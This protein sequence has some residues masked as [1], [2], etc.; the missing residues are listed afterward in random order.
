MAVALPPDAACAE[1][2]MIGLG[3]SDLFPLPN[4]ERD[5]VRGF[6]LIDRLEP[7]TPTLSPAERGSGMSKPRDLA[8]IRR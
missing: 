3:C 1:G 5:R 4:G 7:L 8:S 6:K 2:A